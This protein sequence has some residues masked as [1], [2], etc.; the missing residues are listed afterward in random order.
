MSDAKRPNVVLITVDQW[1]G[2]TLGVAGHPC[3]STPGL[4][5]LARH[6][7]YFPQAVSTA[8]SCV[9]ARRSLFSGK[10]PY[11]HGMVGFNDRVRWDEPQT[12]CQA[13]H[14]AG[15]RTYCVGKRHLFPQNTR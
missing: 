1:R 15:Y 5:I 4:D 12:P 9:A 8:P 6:G 14:T 2:D 3:I 11:H 10:W 7:H 13:F